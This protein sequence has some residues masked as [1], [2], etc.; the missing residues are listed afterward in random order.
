MQKVQYLNNCKIY[1]WGFFFLVPKFYLG[2][3]LCFAP[4]RGTQS[5]FEWIPKLRLGTRNNDRDCIVYKKLLMAVSV[6]KPHMKFIKYQLPKINKLE[7]ITRIAGIKNKHNLDP[8]RIDYTK[9]WWFFLN[10][11]LISRLSNFL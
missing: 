7:W 2:M 8:I 3:H 1:N 11:F 4:Q 5:V 9:S 6:H 10:P